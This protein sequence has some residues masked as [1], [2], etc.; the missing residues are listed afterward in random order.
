MHGHH[1]SLPGT[2]VAILVSA[3]PQ[4]L[5]E[6]LGNGQPRAISFLNRHLD[7]E[8]QDR[9]AESSIGGVQRMKQPN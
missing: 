7:K 2:N 8:R 3:A 4:S 1:R 9:R 6:R 5:D